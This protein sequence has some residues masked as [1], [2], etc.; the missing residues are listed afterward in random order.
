VQDAAPPPVVIRAITV[1]GRRYSDPSHLRLPT[2][3]A[4]LQIDFTAPSLSAPERITFRY[5]LDGVDGG[6]VDP[7]SRRQAFYTKLPP[8]N[9][10]FHVI[11][12]NKDGVWNRQGATLS[13][14][15]PP[16]FLQSWAFKL[17]CA[18]AAAL[19]LWFLYALRM[20]QVAERVSQR[21]EARRSERERIARELHDTLLQGLQGLI[22]RFHSIARRIP[23]TD[24]AR[25]LMEQ[26]LNEADGILIESRDHVRELRSHDSVAN[27]TQVFGDAA[28][29]AN[30]EP[31]TRLDVVTHGPARELHPIVRD[32]ITRIAEQAIQNVAQHA[33]AANLEISIAYERSRLNLTIVDDGVGIPAEI[34]RRGG[35]E[36]HFGLVGLRERA[37][38]IH[39]SLTL[40]SEPGS[41]TR[42]T[43]SVP[44]GVAYAAAAQR[45]PLGLRWPKWREALT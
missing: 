3:A 37:H 36:G 44:A 8:G 42:L 10:R 9:Y 24:P 40:T 19:V 23:D 26:A 16:T 34:L 27:F 2:G 17:L 33:Q 38:R 11:A 5:K 15:L 32:E 35:R 29:K 25:P 4:D 39:G 1:D 12:A 6:W 18:A 30:L 7:G 43:L 22:L 31:R 20:R 13:L 45:A 21:L 41:G 14:E 28:A